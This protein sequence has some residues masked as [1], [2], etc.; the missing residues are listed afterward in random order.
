MT[1]STQ[2]IVNE[3]PVENLYNVETLDANGKFRPVLKIRKV[4]DWTYISVPEFIS[5]D[6]AYDRYTKIE[7]TKRLVKYSRYLVNGTTPVVV[8]VKHYREETN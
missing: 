7:E 6:E 8:E 5:Y 2:E 3:Y 1:K 4:E